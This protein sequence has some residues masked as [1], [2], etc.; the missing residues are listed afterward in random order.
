M[1][2][3][4]NLKGYI[5]MTFDNLIPLMIIVLFLVGI[6]TVGKIA[7]RR[8]KTADDYMIAGR[9]APLFLIVGTLFATFWGGG[10]IIGAT[11]AAYNDGIFGVVED[12]FAAGLALVILGLF[13]VKILRN[14][15]IKSIGELYNKRFGKSAG[16][17]ASAL[18]IP[19]YIIWTAVQLVAIGKIV[20]VLFK[21]NLILHP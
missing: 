16:Y 21:I 12:P 18:M 10:T 1:H 13:F 14:L 2:G 15:K 8:V 9:G 11:G 20:N 19:T 4:T 5:L 17:F 7:S 3:Y 6:I